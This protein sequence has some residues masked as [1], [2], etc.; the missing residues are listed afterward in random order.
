M[1]EYVASVGGATRVP[2]VVRYLEAGSQRKFLLR[3]S[4]C[5]PCPHSVMYVVYAENLARRRQLVRGGGLRAVR[6]TP[7]ML[8]PLVPGNYVTYR[9]PPEL[10]GDTGPVR[11]VSTTYCSTLDAASL[12]R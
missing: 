12:V 1:P 9:G 7:G 11:W 10:T 6:C 4:P 3:V 2:V 5:M 8:T